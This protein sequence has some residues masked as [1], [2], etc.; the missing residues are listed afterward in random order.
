MSRNLIA[1]LRGI[2]S[3]EAVAVCGALI[4]VGIRKVEVTLNSPEPLQSI[5]LMAHEF[6]DGALIGGGTVLGV[7]DVGRIKDAG[8]R[9]IVSPD[10][11]PD[12]ITRTKAMGL[13]SYPGVLT[14]TEC[15]CALRSGADGLKIFPS[16]LMGPA[17]LRAMRAVLPPEITTF[18]VGGIGPPD[19][20]EWISAGVS[21]FGI[22]G[23]IFKPGFSVADVRTRA[24]KIVAAYDAVL[25]S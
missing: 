6:G 20:A 5:A 4:E 13:V 8:G 3:S 18:A 7:Q 23:G 25:A 17:G 2:T 21:G 24:A 9:M 11:N 22:G 12:V 16:F 10:C 19:F 1:I 14:P 15:F